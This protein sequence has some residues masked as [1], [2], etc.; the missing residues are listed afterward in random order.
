[1]IGANNSAI[2]D[3][4]MKAA[5]DYSPALGVPVVA[6]D[7]N[8]VEFV[9][10]MPSGKTA[11]SRISGITYTTVPAVLFTH[12][13]VSRRDLALKGGLLMAEGFA[14]FIVVAPRNGFANLANGIAAKIAAAFPVAR[15]LTLAS[16]KVTIMRPPTPLPG[17]DDGAYWRVPLRVHYRAA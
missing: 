5:L 1:V 9:T 11:P 8:T 15:R 14:D 6:M 3:P 2:A 16:G 12:Q 7:N 4:I 17:Y 10:T 13:P